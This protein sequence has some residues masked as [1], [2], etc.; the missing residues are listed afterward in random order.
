MN[1]ETCELIYGM[2]QFKISSSLIDCVQE[3]LDYLFSNRDFKQQFEDFLRSSFKFKII[4]FN[5]NLQEQFYIDQELKQYLI[6]SGYEN[7]LIS[8]LKNNNDFNKQIAR[9]VMQNIQSK[10]N[11]FID[12]IVLFAP[13]LELHRYIH[14]RCSSLEALIE[15]FLNY[16]VIKSAFIKTTYL[17]TERNKLISKSYTTTKDTLKLLDKISFTLLFVT[18]IIL[19]AI[20]SLS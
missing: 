8:E 7:E 19:S 2:N 10:D 16:Y 12:I 18:V 15:K 13:K 6:D 17:R 14:V 1:R 3:H 9:T 11:N 20:N 5:F 4:E